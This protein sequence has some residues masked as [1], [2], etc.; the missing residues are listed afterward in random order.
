[1]NHWHDPLPD[2][3]SQ[4]ELEDWW[5]RQV[6]TNAPE[7]AEEAAE[8]IQQWWKVVYGPMRVCIDYFVVLERKKERF[9]V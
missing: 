5:D 7:W 4:I 6:E 2:H 1:M 3:C 8:I 9:C